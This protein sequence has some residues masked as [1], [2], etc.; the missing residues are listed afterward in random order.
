M[1]QG[2]LATAE[3]RS[4]LIGGCCIYR[5]GARPVD[6]RRFLGRKRAACAFGPEVEGEASQRELAVDLQRRHRIHLF[7]M[8]GLAV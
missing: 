3:P 5:R 2:I 7:M 4:S 6:Q 1:T 8:H